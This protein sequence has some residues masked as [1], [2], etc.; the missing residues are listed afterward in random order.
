MLGH[1]LLVGAR[2]ALVLTTLCGG[3]LGSASAL[4]QSISLRDMEGREVKLAK[5]AERIAAIPIPVASTVVAFDGST[6][7]LIG[8]NAIAKMA[9]VDGVLGRIYPETKAIRSD[10]VGQNFMPNV[11]TLV[12]AR[13]DLVIQWGGRG[14]DIVKPLAT[15][16]LNTLLILYGTEQYTKDYHRLIGTAMNRVARVDEND[17]WRSKVQAE[18]KSKLATIPAEKRPRVLH[19]ANGLTNLAVVGKNDYTDF[20]IDLSGGRNV[21]EGNGYNVPVNKE[22]IAAWDPEVIF[23]NNF[24]PNLL[25]DF[26]YKDPILSLTKAAKTGR[27]YKLPIGGYRWSPP[28]Q[29]SPLTWMWMANLTHPDVF[30]FDLRAEMKS[31]YRTLYSGYALS[32]AE[33]DAILELP[34]QGNSAN[35]AQFKRR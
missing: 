32:D 35:Y 27:V 4:A 17:A 21:G 6:K 2:A 28:S 25:P 23:L 3:V 14:D 29:E 22:Q 13:P 7:R 8:M 18:F 20:Q 30:K 5:P 24:E 15:A 33:I 26:V 12:A 11:E 9:M 1:V 34:I 16:G 19:I 10:I 31:A